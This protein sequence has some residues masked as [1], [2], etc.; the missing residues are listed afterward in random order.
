MVDLDLISGYRGAR[1][2]A[3]A[4]YALSGRL[5]G[6]DAIY[7]E[8]STFLPAE[9]D[10]AFLGLARALGIPVLTYIR[11]A[12][13]LFPEY[14]SGGGVRRA[15]GRAAFRP[16]FGALAAVSSQLAFP[17]RGLAE[18]LT[19]DA[20]GGIL[21]P[22]GSPPPINI[23]RDPRAK[24]LLF[25]GNGTLEA[26]GAG[27]L[28]E[29]VAQARANGAD[30]ELAIVSR[31]GEEP[32]SRHPDWLMVTNGE[33]PEIRG[34]LPGVIASVIPRPRG[35]YNDLAVPV[36]LYDYLSYGRPLLVTDCLEQARV[37]RQA[38]AGIVV[39]DGPDE[40]GEGIRLLA[41]S[42]AATLDRWA[43]HATRAAT[44]SSWHQRATSVLTALGIAA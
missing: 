35:R 34:L 7:V 12:Y 16:S 24:A 37:V 29:A 25:V 8:S 43:D 30:V 17:S 31:P 44:E 4:R 19:G 14:D 32:P 39:G 5:R 41:Q 20:D 26:Q 13:Q 10:L 2:A 38:E 3:V 27:R 33:G 18:V 28:I 15:I 9:V 22:P 23:R 36:K 42:D 11:D 1:R 6:L 40:I 21:I